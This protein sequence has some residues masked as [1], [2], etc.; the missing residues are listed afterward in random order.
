M[1][2]Q[3]IIM[4]GLPGSGKSTVA[5]ALATRLGIAILSTDVMDGALR[6]SG[7]DGASTGISAYVVAEALAR[8]QLRHGRSVIVDAVNPRDMA[9]QIWRELARQ[10]GAELKVIE[11]VCKDETLLR[12]RVET[13]QR[14]IPGLPALS[15]PHVLR[16]KANYDIWSD[17]R[18]TLET[19]EAEAQALVDT[20]LEF[21]G[22][23]L[24]QS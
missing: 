15:W 6:R 21:L 20:A 10:A 22:Q 1:G 5:G 17:P 12:R 19:D 8:E 7:Y 16:R 23:D 18:L 3:L 4:G 9:R 2:L 11:C 14:D 24:S 13:R